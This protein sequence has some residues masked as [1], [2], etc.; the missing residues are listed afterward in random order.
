MKEKVMV[1]YGTICHWCALNISKVLSYVDGRCDHCLGRLVMPRIKYL[2]LIPASRK[3]QT[4]L[5]K[6]KDGLKRWEGIFLG[7]WLDSSF[8][9]RYK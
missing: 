2:P 4:G 5:G 3:W 8:P 9:I 7:V 6:T 1:A